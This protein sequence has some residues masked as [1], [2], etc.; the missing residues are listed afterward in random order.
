MTMRI[1]TA[2]LLP[3]FVSSILVAQM[4]H[5]LRAGAHDAQEA[6]PVFIERTSGPGDTVRVLALMVQFRQDSDPR[7]TG[8]GRFQLTAGNP[9]LIDPPPHDAT[10]FSYKL[11]F[12]ENYYRKVS[13]SK[14][15]IAGEVF[16]SIVSL[17]DSMAVYSPSRDGSNAPL[18]RLAVD[19]W[20]A[21]SN[22]QPTFPFS[23][24]NAFIVFH[25]GAGRDIDLVSQLGFDPTP[26]DIPS[27]Y[28]SLS[29]LRK[30]LN[31]PA[32]AGIPVNNGAYRI[33][34]TLILP[35][36]ESRVLTTSQG[37]DTLQLGTNGILAATFG[38]FLGLP[39]LFNTKNG[40]SAIGQFGLMDGAGMFAL[41]GL[42]PPEPSAWEKIY[43]GWTVPL[44]IRSNAEIHLP[45]VSFTSAGGDSIYKIPISSREYYLVENRQRD[46]HRNGQ[47]L[48]VYQGGKVVERF[49]SQDTAG[50]QLNDVRGIG[51]VVFD[52][53]DFD[54]ALPGAMAQKGFEGGGILVWHVD[55]KIIEEKLNENEVNADPKRRGVRLIEAD[56][57]ND[58]GENYAPLQAGSGTEFGWP[59]DC[60]FAGNTA[61]PYRNVFNE[62]SYPSSRS[63]NGSPTLITLKN[64]SAP[65][66]RMTLTLELG[67][68]SLRQLDDFSRTLGAS[69][70]S[71]VFHPA[72]TKSGIFIGIGEHVYAFRR[73]GSSK[74]KSQSGLLSA[75]GGASGVAV[76]EEG[77]AETILAGAAARTVYI[78]R[79]SDLNADGVFDTVLTTTY[80]TNADVSTSPSFLRQ[81]SGYSVVVGTAGGGV[82]VIGLDGQLRERILRSTG[83]V[84]SIAQLPTGNPTRPFAIFQSVE[85]Q[86]YGETTAVA[87]PDSALPWIIAGVVTPEGNRIV[88]VER[89]GKKIVA[90]DQSLGSKIFQNT[91]DVGL[92][93][94]VG[95]SDIAGDGKKNFVVQT[96]SALYVLN[97]RGFITDGFPVRL[98]AGDTYVENALVGDVDG[99]G[100][101]DIISVSGQG[102]LAAVTN[103]GKPLAAYPVQVFEPVA[104][105]IALFETPA[106]KVGIVSV[107][108]TGR[109]RAFETQSVYAP[110]KLLWG[111]FL[112]N[113]RRWNADTTVTLSPRPLSSEFFPKAR[114]YNW[115]NPVYGNS[116]QI[117][118]YVSEDAEI[119]I[120]IFDLAGLE[121]AKLQSMARAGID[122]E[123]TWEV[124]DIQSGIYLARI[125]ARGRSRTETA[126]VKI[127]VVK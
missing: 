91:I 109:M 81:S 102:L 47:R 9:S 57:A 53:E 106:G 4:N 105:G 127:A 34:H 65:G 59:L 120:R 67:N 92:I 80:Q 72:V 52:V 43:L 61:P 125:E 50:F 112:Q 100:I 5:A 104:T 78:W 36:T 55:E 126:V 26:N 98:P 30:L 79:A 35:S 75:V 45:A 68:S 20:S 124:F 12:L 123:V 66:A 46:P 121:V 54:W 116:T 99:D 82:L 13:N 60:W 110:G 16:P 117:R 14:L 8:D 25:A 103:R 77:G 44:V 32:Y 51:G 87:F 11:R 62:S 39:D 111:Q 49:F 74:T 63:N 7:T 22:V 15:I 41:R 97:A 76:L 6:R 90:F 2:L 33:P 93:L 27:L 48:N 24:F 114:V 101:A 29:A 107:S 70:S 108:N 42:F 21:A 17:A 1:R 64:F 88:G 118:F 85:G 95:A 19:A 113:E 119:S 73:D 10:Y 86:L 38:S 89:G 96:D 71:K 56:G 115:P 58:I 31:N 28:L 83:T 94:S 122:G 40:R 84:S 18:A 69:S 37:P 23:R 3:F